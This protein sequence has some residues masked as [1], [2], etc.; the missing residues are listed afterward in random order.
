MTLDWLW[1][2]L[3]IKPPSTCPSL[4]NGNVSFQ[5]DHEDAVCWSGQGRPKRNSSHEE[6]T[7]KLI[8]SAVAVQPVDEIQP[9]LEEHTD[10]CTEVDEALVDDEDVGEVLPSFGVAEQDDDHEKVPDHS[11]EPDHRVYNSQW[12]VSHLL[13][14]PRNKYKLHNDAKL[15]TGKIL[16]ISKEERLKNWSIV[17]EECVRWARMGKSHVR[18]FN[19][20]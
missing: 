18:L 1:G 12:H 8:E 9:A 6:A 7:E 20:I 10:C 11:E 4:T 15:V 17:S 5:G 19:S 3:L 13:Q 14:R 16:F 2:H